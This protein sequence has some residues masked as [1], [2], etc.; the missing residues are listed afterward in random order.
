MVTWAIGTLAMT[1]T[2]LCRAC[3]RGSTAA[4]CRTAA[5]T[6]SS[7]PK[8][9]DTP[10]TI[11]CNNTNTSFVSPCLCNIMISPLHTD[12]SHILTHTHTHIPPPPDAHPFR[13]TFS[14][15]PTSPTWPC[16]TSCAGLPFFPPRLLAL[17]ANTQQGLPQHIGWRPLRSC[18]SR[19]FTCSLSI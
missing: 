6:L 4:C 8:G 3:M 16:P 15:L 1:R 11:P 14:I 5:K 2:Q 10:Q 7:K 9:Q 17:L 12:N 19:F 13:K 18:T